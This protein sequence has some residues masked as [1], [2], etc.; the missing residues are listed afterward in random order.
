MVVTRGGL[1]GTIGGGALEHQAPSRRARSSR[2][3]G[4]L[5]RA[6]LSAG[7]LLGQCCGG[8]VRLL[9]EHL[10]SVPDGEGPFEVTCPIASAHA[11]ASGHRAGPGLRGERSSQRP[12]PNAGA[13]FVE[14][15]KS[16]RLPSC[17]SAPAMSAAPS[18]PRAAG[19]PLDLAW[20]DSR[21]RPPKRRASCSPRGRDGRLRGRGARGGG[22]RILTHD[23]ALDYAS[24]PP[25]SAAA[26]ASSG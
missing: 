16:D 8:R 2:S 5:A 24:P 22:G 9:V 26:R 6:G 21:P 1:A 13:S 14:P 11:P 19:V 10:E 15:S 25:R 18:P 3:R 20:Y 4:E 12:A 17:S 7:P 23:H